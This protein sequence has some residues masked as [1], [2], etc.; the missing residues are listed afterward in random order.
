MEFEIQFYRKSNRNHI[1]DFILSLD[2]E[3]KL[4]I[5]AIFRKMEETPFALG[6]LSK[7]VKNVKNLFELKIRAKNVTIRFF[8]CYKK[9]KIIII[10]HGFVK[11]SQKIPSKELE[12]AIKRKKEIE[13]E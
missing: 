10:L 5:L 9:N 7:K 3:A 8:Y 4:D 13:N 12:I 2:E 11:K 1:L 6:S